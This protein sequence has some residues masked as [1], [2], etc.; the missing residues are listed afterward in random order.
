MAHQY[1][2]HFSHFARNAVALY[3]ADA[4]FARRVI[5]GFSGFLWYCCWLMPML[6]ASTRSEI[7]PCRPRHTFGY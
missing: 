5:G 1:Q 4:G 2:H 3:S 7:F 6:A